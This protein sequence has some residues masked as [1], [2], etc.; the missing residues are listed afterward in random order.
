MSASGLSS[1]LVFNVGRAVLSGR[2]LYSRPRAAGS[3]TKGLWVLA[4]PASLRY[5]LEQDAL[6]LA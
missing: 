5:F 4:S 6:I 2:V 1:P 3:K